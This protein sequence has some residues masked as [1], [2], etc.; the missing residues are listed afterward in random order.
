MA[1]GDRA[2]TSSCAGGLIH[3][4]FAPDDCGASKPMEFDATNPILSEMTA[5]RSSRGALIDA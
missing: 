5:W 3:L 1:D 2:P 4:V